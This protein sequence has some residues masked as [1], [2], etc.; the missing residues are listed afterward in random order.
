MASF[1]ISIFKRGLMERKVVKD[2]RSEVSVET[3][4]S[5]YDREG[6]DVRHGRL[7]RRKGRGE[8][9]QQYIFLKSSCSHTAK[10]ASI[11]RIAFASL[12]K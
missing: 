5:N 11:Y 9:M 1:V 6:G 4:P 2:R 8:R 3:V 7:G 12:E 10:N